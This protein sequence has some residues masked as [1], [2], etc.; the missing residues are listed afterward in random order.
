MV[1]DPSQDFKSFVETLS[2]PE[3]LSLAEDMQ[4]IPEDKLHHEIVV[5]ALTAKL[6]AMKRTTSPATE[7]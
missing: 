2:P 5:Q 6:G 3:L 4:N 1:F 7:A